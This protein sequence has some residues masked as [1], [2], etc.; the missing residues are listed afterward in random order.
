MGKIKTSRF[1]GERVKEERLR[2]GFKTQAQAAA[3]FGVKRETWSRYETDK[4]E[5]GQEVFRR[6]VE[7]GADPDSIVTGIR[8]S[9]FEA[10]GEKGMPAHMRPGREGEEAALLRYFRFLPDMQ[11]K[12]I[13]GLAE[14]LANFYFAAR[15][16]RKKSDDAEIAEE[17]VSI[18]L[19]HHE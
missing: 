9:V 5:I 4:L 6:L 1:S 14:S 13:L 12:Q 19:H 7:A 17:Q 18:I 10:M 11:R 15:R 16:A 3:R 2:L 8:S